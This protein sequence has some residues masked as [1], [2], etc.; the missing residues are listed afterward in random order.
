MWK[1]MF[2]KHCSDELLVSHLDGELSLRLER[3]VRRHLRACWRCRTRRAELEHQVR[4]VSKALEE[5]SDPGPDWVV[6]ARAKFLQ[7]VEALERN[8][9][10]I[11][12]LR[13]VAAFPSARPVAIAASLLLFGAALGVWFVTK[14]PEANDIIARAREADAKL[15]RQPVHQSFV[16]EV[17]QVRPARQKRT[18]QLELWSESTGGRFASRWEQPD[19]SLKHAIWRPDSGEAYV[20]RAAATPGLLKLAGHSPKTISLVELSADELNLEAIERSFV[21]WL[22]DRPWRP[23][24]L[25]EELAVF[26]DTDGAT[27]QVERRSDPSSGE[28]VISLCATRSVGSVQAEITVLV[29]G[30]T[31]R[32]HL[33]KI[34]LE[35]PDRLVEL[36]VILNRAEP[37]SPN[38]FS[39][40]VFEPH[41]PSSRAETET[42]VA[43]VRPTSREQQKEFQPIAEPF[44]TKA[45]K[46]SELD[47]AEIEARYAL[48]RV[49][50]C[51]GEPVELMRDPKGRIA[52]RGL[53]RTSARKD[54]LLEAV[55]D[56]QDLSFVSIEVQTVEEAAE[57]ASA[58]FA[59][60]GETS[61]A[62]IEAEPR[63]LIHLSS[64]RLPIEEQLEHYF[65]ERGNEQQ[66]VP[67]LSAKEEITRFA[68][69]AVLLSRAALAEAWAL[70]RLA[71]RYGG[72]ETHD[73]NRQSLW[74]LEV[75]LRDHITA[76][77]E[78]VLRARVKL[79]PVLSSIQG[80]SPPVVDD[81]AVVLD[82]ARVGPARLTDSNWPSACVEL[83]HLVEQIDA[84]LHSLFA[85]DELVAEG[86]LTTSGPARV[87][88]GQPEEVLADLVAVLRQVE[89]RS[90][91]LTRVVENVSR[92][93]VRS[94][95]RR[96][97]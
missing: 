52:I 81:Q 11:S 82:K 4:A 10:P 61:E 38:G 2:L 12:D 24:S 83:F 29:S 51:L 43:K 15:Y 49:S 45:P 67:G 40:A 5:Q 39:A 69:E 88:I 20:Y 75:M 47:T 32:P 46:R 58:T 41:V 84:L 57:T 36:R 68:N 73:L 78:H 80:L 59:R 90:M 74:L 17:E 1:M 60:A 72:R 62:V 70:R 42:A 55:K 21:K 25:A 63:P 23:I 54:E 34:R 56:L 48:H 95:Q 64:S 76:L 93:D 85:S 92:P 27:V 35:T 86:T 16:V 87:R 44:L 50:A 33:K 97:K 37:A 91:S 8:P 77:Q 66:A 31:Y 18:S 19:G 26:T 3:R 89:T 14:R 53:A 65:T 71:E 6:Q 94:Q 30:R 79:E 9:R 22:E 28:R 96:P 7:R 13:F